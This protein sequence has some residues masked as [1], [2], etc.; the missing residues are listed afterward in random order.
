M[1]KLEKRVLD[2]VQQHLFVIFCIA[3]TLCSMMIRF[4]FRKFE[5]GDYSGCLLPWWKEIREAG[6]IFALKEQVGNYNMLYQLLIA[7]MT[8]LPIK[9]LYE[10]K[11]LSIIFDYLLAAVV[12]YLIYDML[13]KDKYKGALAYAV[14]IMSPIVFLNSSAWS[15]CDAIYVFFIILSLLFVFNEHYILSFAM[16]GIAFSF[17]LQTIFIIPFFVFLYVYKKRFSILNFLLIPLMMC[18]TAIPCLVMGRN[19]REVF[20]NYL[21]Q[22]ETYSS[23]SMNYPSIWIIFSRGGGFET[24]KNPAIIVTVTIL[25]IFVYMW[26]RNGHAFGKRELLKGAFLIAYTCVLFLP[27]MHERY[28]YL[29]EILAIMLAFIDKRTILLCIVLNMLSVVTYGAYLYHTSYNDIVLAAINVATYI[30]YLYLLLPDLTGKADNKQ[31][32]SLC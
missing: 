3:V 31:R 22:V 28:G 7:L 8:Y 14:V 6:G 10:Y 21:L 5:S 19:V 12:G 17:K 25:G 23:M 1:S 11:I 20:F 15:Q 2:W 29:Y 26:L 24:L 4:Y 32:S 13:G 27:D 30:L 9:P 18:I 16:V